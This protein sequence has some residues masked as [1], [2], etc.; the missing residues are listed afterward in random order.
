[1]TASKKNRVKFVPNIMLL[2]ASARND[3]DEG[4]KKKCCLLERENK[5]GKSIKKHHWFSR[6][7]ALLLFNNICLG[8]KTNERQRDLL[9]LELCSVKKKCRKCFVAK[10]ERREE[11]KGR[12]SK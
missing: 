11:E 8:R 12:R 10:K 3:L 7:S 2:E 5:N 4:N 9:L 6:E 1:M